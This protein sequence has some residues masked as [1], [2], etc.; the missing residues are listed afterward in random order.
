MVV[1]AGCGGAAADGMDARSSE[2]ES[3]HNDLN[4]KG[5]DDALERALMMLSSFFCRD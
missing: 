3:V 2:V 5:F 1:R 4:V